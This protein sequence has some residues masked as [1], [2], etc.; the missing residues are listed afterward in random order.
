MT[1]LSFE[2]MQAAA[3]AAPSYVDVPVEAWG[4]SVRLQQLSAA[5]GIAFGQRQ[6]DQAEAGDD[7]VDRPEELAEQYI[8]LL[9]L[10]IVDGDGRQA[11][12]NEAGRAFLATQPFA[13]LNA[14]GMAAMRLN[15]FTKAEAA[16]R[17]K[18]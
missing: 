6:R 14:L 11:L 4:G 5:D 3:G 18:N 10:S 2:Q 16:A 9:S 8:Y 17:E 13:V 12:H 1:V 15:G 7:D